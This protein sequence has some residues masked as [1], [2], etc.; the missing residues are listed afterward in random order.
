MKL[1]LLQG[2]GLDTNPCVGTG[3]KALSPRDKKLELKLQ[4]EAR[5]KQCRILKQFLKK[6]ISFG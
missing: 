5:M 2:R 6:S 4:H 1:Q 3:D